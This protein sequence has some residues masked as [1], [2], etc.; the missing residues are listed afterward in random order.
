MNK[1]ATLFLALAMTCVMATSFTACLAGGGEQTGGEQTGGNTQTGNNTQTGDTTQTGGEE[2]TNTVQQGGMTEEEWKKAIGDTFAS[3]AITCEI[4]GTGETK[5]LIENKFIEDGG[6]Y[7]GICKYDMVNYICSDEMSVIASKETRTY[8]TYL[9]V[10]GADVNTYYYADSEWKV[11]TRTGASEEAAKLAFS[12]LTEQ[13]LS[14]VSSSPLTGFLSY[15]K[16]LFYQPIA[17]IADRK[18][19]YDTIENLYPA[20][21]YDGTTQAY[22]MSLSL[23]GYGGETQLF[24]DIYFSEGK[25]SKVNTAMAYTVLSGSSPGCMNLNFT[26]TFGYDPVE[27]VVPQEALDAATAGN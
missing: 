27:I 2:N 5:Q 8:K 22:S 19:M 14:T 4:T 18:A 21:K 15:G 25:I 17:V 24:V 16:S 20:F 1:T 3:D 7:K 9:A 26:M 10:N 11:S 23:P 6:E 13:P 12:S